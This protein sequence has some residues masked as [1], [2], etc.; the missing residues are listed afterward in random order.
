MARHY[1]TEGTLAAWA[2]LTHRLLVIERAARAHVRRPTRARLRELR[3][4]LARRPRP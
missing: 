4:V 1:V 2:A 3:R